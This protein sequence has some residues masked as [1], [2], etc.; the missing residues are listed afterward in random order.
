MDSQ[1]QNFSLGIH[2]KHLERNRPAVRLLLESAF[3]WEPAPRLHLPS[4]RRQA[5]QSKLSLN[6]AE[7][8]FSTKSGLT[9]YCQEQ[10]SPGFA[11]SDWTVL[12]MWAVWALFWSVWRKCW[13]VKVPVRLRFTPTT[14]M[15]QRRT[16]VLMKS[17]VDKVL[18]NTDVWMSW[19][20]WNVLGRRIPRLIY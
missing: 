1:S 15:C 4:R 14:K 11:L 8:L 3:S 12:G 20:G 7:L 17:S 18:V 10:S 5:D 19:N 13:K 16:E 2:R 6:V 9:H